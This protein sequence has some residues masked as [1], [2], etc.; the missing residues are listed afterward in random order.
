MYLSITPSL[1]VVLDGQC[2]VQTVVVSRLQGCHKLRFCLDIRV[3][4]LPLTLKIVKVWV[5]LPPTS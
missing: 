5:Q 1:T 3:F 4:E 2:V